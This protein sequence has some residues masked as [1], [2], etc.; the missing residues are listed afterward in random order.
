MAAPCCADPIQRSYACNDRRGAFPVFGL[1]LLGF[2]C[3]RRHVLGDR[4]FEVLNRFVITVTLPVLAF[5]ALAQMHA[6]D[7][8]VPGIIAAVLDGAFAIYAIG[9]S[10]ERALGQTIVES[11]IAGLAACFSNTGFAGLPIVLLTYGPASLAPGAV[12]MALYASIVFALAI[13][14]SEMATDDGGIVRGLRRA[15]RAVCR[16]PL[17]VLCVLGTVWS[18]LDWPLA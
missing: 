7:L 5:R 11:N 8:A 17:I 9:Y 12:A 14:I 10:I 1:I 18:V 13:F 2:G 3:S 16:S 4:A 15:G 6:G